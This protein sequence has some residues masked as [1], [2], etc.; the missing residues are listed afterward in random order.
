VPCDINF[1]CTMDEK[2]KLRRL[3][4]SLPLRGELRADRMG[5]EYDALT[6]LSLFGPIRVEM[7]GAD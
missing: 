2:Q 7:S 3:L 6:T 1:A 4:T 5:D